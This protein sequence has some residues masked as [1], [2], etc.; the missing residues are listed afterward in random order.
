MK[1]KIALLGFGNEN[2]A[3]Y[4]Y[5][6]AKE[7]KIDIYDEKQI[8]IPKGFSGKFIVGLDLEQEYGEVFKSPGISFRKISFK[9][10][11]FE[12]ESE[13][14]SKIRI[15]SLTNLLFSKLNMSN[16]IVV[17]GTKGK[18]TT[19][20]LINHILISNGYKSELLGNIGNINTELLDQEDSQSYYVFE[21]SSFQTEFL[22]FSP[23]FAVFT[24]FFVDHQD[25][26]AGVQEYLKAKLNLI[27]HQ[28]ENDTVIFA[29]QFLNQAEKYAND[30]K[31]KSNI[32][33]VRTAETKFETKLLGEHNQINCQLA[34][35]TCLK[36]GLPKDKIVKSIETYQPLSGR[37]ELVGQYN[38]IDFYADDL[39]TIPEATWAAIQSFETLQIENR[40]NSTKDESSKTTKKDFSKRL[41]TI[42]LGGYDKGLDYE[43]LAKNLVNSKIKN[44]IYF[45]PTGSLITKY[46]NPKKVI[47]QNAKDMKEAVEFA[48][49]LTKPNSICLLSCAS[50]SFGLF[51]NVY[52]RAE[53][54]RK[55]VKEYTT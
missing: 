53:Q 45:D 21:L 20:S 52:Q 11:K 8:K 50:A 37:L 48:Y 33:V 22:T 19:A 16:V 23:K 27:S 36:I 35:E 5:F 26:H 40:Q 32:I 17:T 43:I 6:V 25:V 55:Y 1:N 13:F 44:F 46:L 28:K 34:T 47:V 18:S 41:E 10:H 42:I 12:S 38:N 2:Q 51:K 15:N 54:Y 3:L 24:S 9:G 14:R 49:K 7:F 4:E 30:F 39:A 31:I 29:E